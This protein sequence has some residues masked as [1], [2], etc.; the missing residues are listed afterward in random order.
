[1][2]ISIAPEDI[3]DAA[4]FIQFFG[5]RTKLLYQQKNAIS[6]LKKGKQLPTVDQL[7]AELTQQIGNQETWP[8][9]NRRML[10]LLRVALADI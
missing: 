2:V 8:R 7:T 9:D 4:T 5:T 10:V 6:E 3:K 1:M